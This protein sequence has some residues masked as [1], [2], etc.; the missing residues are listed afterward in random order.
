MNR[1][2]NVA[3]GQQEVQIIDDQEGKPLCSKDQETDAN[4]GFTHNL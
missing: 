3:G 2:T 4:M 1:E